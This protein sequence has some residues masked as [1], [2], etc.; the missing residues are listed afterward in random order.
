MSQFHH[1]SMII[2]LNKGQHAVAWL[3]TFRGFTPVQ[4]QRQTSSARHLEE[5]HPG[6]HLSLF[7][8]SVVA[9]EW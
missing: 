5:K 9:A 7:Y 8:I 3:P 1:T 4:A 6:L 2:S